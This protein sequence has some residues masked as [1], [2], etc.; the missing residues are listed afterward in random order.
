MRLLGRF[1]LVVM[2]GIAV[3]GVVMFLLNGR[4]I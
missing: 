2:W 4:Q 3:A 1:V